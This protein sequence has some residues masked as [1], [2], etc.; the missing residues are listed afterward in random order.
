MTSASGSRDDATRPV[1]LLDVGCV[2]PLPA[3]RTTEASKAPQT[4]HPDTS[5]RNRTSAGPWP[6]TGRAPD[7]TRYEVFSEFIEDV[8]PMPG[9]RYVEGRACAEA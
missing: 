6:I 4:A 5:S 3:P 8:E 1:L 7:R 9:W 2:L